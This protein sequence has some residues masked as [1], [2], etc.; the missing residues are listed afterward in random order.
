MSNIDE[1][2]ANIQAIV[3]KNLKDEPE[4]VDEFIFFLRCWFCDKYSIPFSDDKAAEMTLEELLLEFYIHQKYQDIKSGKTKA[5]KEE[6]SDEAWLKEQMGQDYHT[7]D[8]KL[9]KIDKDFEYINEE[10]YLGEE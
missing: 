1:V 8:E 6:E 4:T 5:I 2:I 7:E 9:D 3:D 10:F